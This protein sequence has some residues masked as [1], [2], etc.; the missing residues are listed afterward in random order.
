M[1]NSDDIINADEYAGKKI[2]A[3][4]KKHNTSE[5]Y[6]SRYGFFRVV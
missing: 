5:N 2:S 1:K 4:A 6:Y 3:L